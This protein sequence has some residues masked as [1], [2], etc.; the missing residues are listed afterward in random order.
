[1][2]VHDKVEVTVYHPQGHCLCAHSRPF[3]SQVPLSGSN[4]ERD[5]VPLSCLFIPTPTDFHSFLF[6]CRVLIFLRWPL[7][8]E[9]VNRYGTSSAHT[10]TP[11]HSTSH[12]RLCLLAWCF[13]NRYWF[14]FI[15]FY[16][17]DFV[18]LFLASKRQPCHCWRHFFA[19]I[20]Y[21]IWLWEVVFSLWCLPS[22][23]L[24]GHT[25]LHSCARLPPP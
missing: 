13:I 7:L 20:L 1:M 6:I 24:C 19:E 15:Y 8:S 25:S 12:P 18:P 22:S 2:T 5:L 21:L 16:F 4:V 17:E 14:S 11:E 10:R 23:Y 9:M 3:F